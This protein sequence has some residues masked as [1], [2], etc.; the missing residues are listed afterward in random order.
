MSSVDGGGSSG[1]PPSSAEFDPEPA[2]GGDPGARS[3]SRLSLAGLLDPDA[4]EGDADLKARQILYA[5]LSARFESARFEAG[6]YPADAEKRWLLG[7]LSREIAAIDERLRDQVNAILHAP[8]LQRMEARWRGLHYLTGAAEQSAQVKIRFLNLGWN[9]VVRDLERAPDFDASELFARIY[10]DEFGMPGGEP[11]GLLLGDYE[12]RHRPGAGHLTDD[13]GALKTLAMIAEAAFAPLVLGVSPSVLQ[14]DSFRELGRPFNVGD[15]FSQ[16]ES[17]R[18]TALRSTESAR[19]LGLVLP[20]ILMRAPYGP[21]SNRVDGFDFTELVDDPSGQA[22]LW[23]S[24]AFAFA[25]IVIRAFAV[26][27][28]FA[29][30]RGAPRDEIRGGLVTDLPVLSFATDRPGIAV[31][32]ST[33]CIISDSQDKD[34]SDLGFIVLRKVAFTE[35]SAFYANAS[36]Q[37]PARHDSVATNTNAKLSSMLQYILCVSRFAHYIKI[38]GRDLVGSIMTAEECEDLL[39]RWILGYCEGSDSASQEA[40]ARRPLKEAS[41]TVRETPGSPGSYGCTVYLR[42]HFQ[43]DDISGGFR[44]VTELVPRRAA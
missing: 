40:K 15:V 43:L 7:A 12:V 42:P 27:G 31:K 28:W 2:A 8:P 13:V 1:P 22:Y 26:N 4:G 17:Q 21:D 5:L 44:L 29:D 18:C 23:G 14:L 6:R 33:E 25:G 20:R 35:Y 37:L 9:E 19:F 32:P 10:E 39:S 11:Y 24:A 30:L 34:L 3:S 41:I 36:L 38:I 16:V